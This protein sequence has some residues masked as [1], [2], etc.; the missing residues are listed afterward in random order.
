MDRANPTHRPKDEN[1]AVT[2]MTV[3][4]PAHQLRDR[5][6]AVIEMTAAIHPHPC[7]RDDQID[8]AAIPGGA[9][10]GERAGQTINPSATSVGRT[11]G[12]SAWLAL[13]LASD[14]GR[15]VT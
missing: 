6:D 12:G 7:H 5:D 13:G 15:R 4:N 1:D 8:D 2:E 14:V 11:I 9:S 10:R 3:A